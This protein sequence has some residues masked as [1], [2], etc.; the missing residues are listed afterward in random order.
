MGKARAAT[1]WITPGGY[2]CVRYGDNAFLFAHPTFWEERGLFAVR[3]DGNPQMRGYGGVLRCPIAAELNDIFWRHVAPD[4]DAFDPV[5]WVDAPRLLK[6][7]ESKSKE[8]RDI[9]ENG[10]IPLF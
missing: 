1:R 9:E 3:L 7:M 6:R 10:L 5:K 2:H 4:L 8:R